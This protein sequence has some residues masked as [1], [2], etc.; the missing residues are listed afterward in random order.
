MS[1]RIASDA[2]TANVADA[3]RIAAPALAAFVKRALEAAGLRSDDAKVVADLMV[4]ADLRGSDTHGVIR[5]PLYLRRLKA[6]G[7]NP[8]ADI[9]IVQERPAT[10]L[11]DGDNGI[12]HLVMRFAAMTA[13]E[14]AKGAGV[15]WVGAR[16][17]NHAGPAALYAMMPLAHDMIGLYLAVGSN[18]HLP[19]WGSTENLLGTNPIAIAVPAKEEPP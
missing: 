5:L 15:A 11:V 10:A 16:M 8:R 1:G 2:K 3:P 12:G 7:I 18:N 19:P 6:G 17:S 13:I 9:R 4:E 14:K